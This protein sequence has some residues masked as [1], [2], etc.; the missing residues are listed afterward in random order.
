MFLRELHWWK[1]PQPG[2]R[3]TGMLQIEKRLLDL[4]TTM[5]RKQSKKQNKQ[6]KTIQFQALVI[7]YIKE[8]LT[9]TELGKTEYREFPWNFHLARLNK[10]TLDF[11]KV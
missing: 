8:R 6:I 5:S 9:H 3:G 4:W 1:Y 11:L 2:I 7:A 10:N